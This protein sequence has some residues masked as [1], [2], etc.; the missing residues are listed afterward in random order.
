MLELRRGD[1]VEFW[2]EVR[3]SEYDVPN[4]YIDDKAD[5]VPQEH[6]YR[7]EVYLRRGGQTYDLYGYQSESIINDIIDQFEKYLHFLNM[8]PDSLPWRMQEHD[9]DI[10]LE[11]G[12]V[13]DK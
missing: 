12:S 11:Q 5:G 10:T 3:L 4:Y 6:H 1:N 9:E 8:A 7:A 2:Y 13:F